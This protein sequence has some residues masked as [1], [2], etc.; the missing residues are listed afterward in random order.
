MS[1]V[2]VTWIVKRYNMR[3]LLHGFWK[4]IVIF[5]NMCNIGLEEI[6]HVRG[7]HFMDFEDIWQRSA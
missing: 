6:W 2:D 1:N 4:Y 7:R 3:K 5:R